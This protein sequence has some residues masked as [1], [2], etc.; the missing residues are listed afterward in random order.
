MCKFVV[1]TNEIL[2]NLNKT[3][4]KLPLQTRICAVVKANAY[5]FGLN[6]ICNLLKSGV[7]YFAVARLNEFLKFK[8]LEINKPC[9]ILSP[10]TLKET[11][12][13]V[14]NGAE[15][16]VDNVEQVEAL[17]QVCF[18]SDLKAKIHIKFDTGMNRYGV[19]EAEIL[20]IMLK[21]IQECDKVQLIGCY[22]HLYEGKNE[23]INRIQRQKFVRFRDIVKSFG[24]KA[25]FHLANSEG[26]KDVLN[27]YN[28]VRVGY[29]LYTAQSSEHKF[30]CDIR[31]IKVVKKG[32]TISY[33]SS[34]KAKKDMLIAVCSAGYADGV[35]RLLSKKG[36]VLI[37]G[38][39]AKILG[40][41]CMDCF[42]ADIT[43]INTKIGDE[44]VIF[45]KS[46]EMAISVCEVAQ[47]CG[48][49]P[50]EI[51]TS[52]SD[53]VKRVYQWRNHANYYW[54]ISGKKVVK[55]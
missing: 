44:V 34:F 7:D 10:L 39:K 3:R 31:E 29:D 32:E 12:V 21:K 33:N 48:T 18:N 43:Q 52:I 49:I 1:S 14:K 13:A 51:Y 53:R 42:M 38:Q 55:S 37:N 11:I 28:M 9:L 36:F 27:C 46:K 22:S 50:Y 15:I 19:K 25:I 17:V 4:A 45:G 35:N 8:E 30:V 26:L 20:K 40:N 6:K 54:K 2:D 41:V 24:F 5:G 23:N 47:L 16:T